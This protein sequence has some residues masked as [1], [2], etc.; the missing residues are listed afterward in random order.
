[1]EKAWLR[2]LEDGNWSDS[3]DN[4]FIFFLQWFVV[5]VIYK[6]QIRNEMVAKCTIHSLMAEFILEISLVKPKIKQIGK[7]GRATKERYGRNPLQDKQ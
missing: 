4:S 7:Q 5:S 3:S 1:M 6:R 2:N